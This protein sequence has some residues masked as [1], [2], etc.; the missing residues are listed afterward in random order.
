[1]QRKA[2]IG[3][4]VNAKDDAAA[5]D[6]PVWLLLIHQLP[7]RPAYARVKLW[8]RFHVIGAVAVKHAVHALPAGEQALEDFAWLVKEIVDA[9]GEALLCEAVDEV[10]SVAPLFAALLSLPGDRYPPLNLSPQKQKE[11]TLETLVTNI[12]ALAYS[13]RA[14]SSRSKLRS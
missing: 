4:S 6:V 5:R 8:R 9:G 12:K 10:K 1:M 14:S 3:V 13:S 11:K 2:D 7:A